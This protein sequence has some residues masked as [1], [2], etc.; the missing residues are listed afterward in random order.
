MEELGCGRG[1]L[2]RVVLCFPSCDDIRHLM[3]VPQ[4]FIRWAGVFHWTVFVMVG[5]IDDSQNGIVGYVSCP[6][7][8]GFILLVP[9]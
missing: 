3:A 6:H 8:L 5:V 2:M 4:G 7:T 9:V 1:D